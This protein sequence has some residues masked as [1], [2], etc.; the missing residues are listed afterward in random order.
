M[1]KLPDIHFFEFFIELSSNNNKTW[2]DNHRQRYEE[3]VKAPFEFLVEQLIE[4]L[5]THDQSFAGL[6]AGNC[7]FRI[8]KDVRFSKDKAPYKLNRSAIIAPGGRK[9]MSDRGFYIEMGPES[10]GFYAGSYM[11]DKTHL[12]AIR[13]KITQ[14]K[15]QWK[16]IIQSDGFI[17]TFGEVRGNRQVKGDAAFK[18]WAE[19]LPEVRN[20]QFYIHH[21]IEPELFLE[22][23]PVDYLISL[24]LKAEAFSRFV[25]EAK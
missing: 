1:A 24:W 22:Q 9:G 20:T 18:P 4:K 7:I 23:N 11:P 14:Q 3:Q 13:H 8:N 2:F 17:K 6:N 5:K 10:C 19:D 21:P 15:T 12:R 25:S 16:R